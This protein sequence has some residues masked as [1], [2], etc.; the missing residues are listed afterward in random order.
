M[1]HDDALAPLQPSLQFDPE[2]IER[3]DE[4]IADGV[5]L[6]RRAVLRVGLTTAG[7]ALLGAS[8]R[9]G[10]ET[11]GDAGGSDLGGAL[12]PTQAGPLAFD[13]FLATLVPLARQAIAASPQNEEAYLHTLASLMTRLGDVPDVEFTP[14]PLF[15]HVQ[16]GRLHGGL[17][18]PVSVTQVRVD[19]GAEV[20]PH[21]HPGYTGSLLGLE[22]ELFLRNFDIVD[23]DRSQTP[24]RAFTV[25]QS[26]STR[27]DAGRTNSLGS[28]REN[29]HAVRSGDTPARVL[30]IFTFFG[31]PGRSGFFELAEQPRDPARGLYEAAWS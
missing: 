24:G 25:R 14:F 1:W 2:T 16:T 11:D 27:L 7:L 9:A 13:A 31:Q 12:D 10:D 15:E 22:G 29:L 4:E 20:P 6:E 17:G 5:H 26:S 28:V 8:A 21:N 18:F 3:V 23:G 30:D 19:A